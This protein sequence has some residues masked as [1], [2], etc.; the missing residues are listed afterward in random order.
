MNKRVGKKDLIFFAILLVVGIGLF[1]FY[2]TRS[3]EQ[4]QRIIIARDGEKYGEYSLEKY[5]SI[6]VKD[7]D[8][9]VTNVVVIEDGVVHMES[10][11]CPDH[12]CML[13][14][15][16]SKDKETIVCLPNKVTVTVVGADEGTLDAVAN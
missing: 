9:K 7:K 14:K 10:A 13:Q 15:S 4:G 11:S 12:L 16:I 1:V 6:S 2:Q 3:L 8:D 5:Q